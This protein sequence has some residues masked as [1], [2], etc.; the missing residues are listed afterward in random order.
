MIRLV[1]LIAAGVALYL[2][3]RAPRLR[4][5]EAL[6]RCLVPVAWVLLA[7]VYVRALIDLVPDTLGPIGLLDD[8]IVLVS[9]IWWARR[10]LRESR[11]AVDRELPGEPDP[12][13]DPYAVLDVARDASAEEITRAYRERM[14]EYHPDRVAGLGA[15]LQ[16]VA[17]EKTLEIQRAYD[18]LRAP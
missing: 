18:A 14:K 4:R 16:K 8:L 10:L 1:L 13:W 6:R 3:W 2:W 11:P 7:L 17:H 9:A 15:E 12:A 5:V